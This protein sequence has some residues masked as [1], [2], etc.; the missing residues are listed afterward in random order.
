MT[1]TSPI[2]TGITDPSFV[3]GSHLDFVTPERLSHPTHGEIVGAS[4]V[5]L[6]TPDTVL[7]NQIVTESNGVVEY[8]PVDADFASD[9]LCNEE[10]AYARHIINPMLKHIEEQFP[11]KR[12]ALRGIATSVN[13]DLEIPYYNEPVRDVTAVS[14][15]GIE[16]SEEYFNVVH[17]IDGTDTMSNYG[18]KH[19]HEY[20][21]KVGRLWTEGYVDLFPA[22]L[23]YDAD[24]LEEVEKGGR[25]TVGLKDGY[26]PSNALL[27]I[28]ITD[29]LAGQD[30]T[31]SLPLPVDYL[32]D[33][34]YE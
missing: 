5:H 2:P 31:T 10:G 9:R 3:R 26:N 34:D 4:G 23:V 7:V 27:K 12:I 24:M 6:V 13:G 18:L 28:Y 33:V 14:R 11:G 19:M 22:I 20:A 29:K 17:H 21:S 8:S 15:H 25:Y 30:Q 1:E 32:F 16:K